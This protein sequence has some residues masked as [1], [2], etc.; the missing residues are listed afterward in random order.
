MTPLAHRT[1]FIAL[2]ICLASPAWGQ[3]FFLYTPKPV[4]SGQNAPSQDGILVQEVEIQ[5]GDTLYALSRKFSGRGMF[6]PQILLFN[7]I[8]NPN[9]IYPGNILKIPVTQKEAGVQ[10]STYSKPAGESPKPK[11]SGSK[12]SPGKVAPARQSSAPAPVSNQST[13]LSLSELKAGGAEKSRVTRTKKKNAVHAKK[14]KTRQLPSETNTSPSSPAVHTGNAAAV[15]VAD[16]SAGQILFEEAVT[17]YR[18]NDCRT[19]LELLDRYLA[20][21]SGSPLAADANLY[22]AECYLKLSAQ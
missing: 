22:K 7:S 16:T 8:K 1:I 13:E 21:Y 6:F 15:P 14:I 12:K 11:T 19:A 4:P 2:I 18:R 5:K 20:D 9:L 3:Q 17:A 10:D